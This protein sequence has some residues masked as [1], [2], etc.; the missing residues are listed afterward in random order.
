MTTPPRDR[1]I[2]PK[3]ESQIARKPAPT[4]PFPAISITSSKQL[5][6][7]N[8]PLGRSSRTTIYRLCNCRRDEAAGRQANAVLTSLGALVA[9]HKGENEKDRSEKDSHHHRDPSGDGCP[10]RCA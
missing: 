4:P 1:T 8:Q 6:P 9:E 7:H 5:R 3:P 2:H 10:D